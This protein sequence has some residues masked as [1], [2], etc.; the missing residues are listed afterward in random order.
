M[1]TYLCWCDGEK[2]SN[3]KRVRASDSYMAVEAW[4]EDRSRD[5]RPSD[6]KDLVINV[7]EVGCASTTQ[8][9]LESVCMPVFISSEPWAQMEE[10]LY[11][12]AKE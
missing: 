5:H 1:Q 12:T 3:A 11:S 8:Y 9:R 6:M 4:I 10:I 7:L 2:W